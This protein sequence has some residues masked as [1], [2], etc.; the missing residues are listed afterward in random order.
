MKIVCIAVLLGLSLGP[1][2]GEDAKKAADV[3]KTP[4]QVI[5]PEEQT[6][7]LARRLDGSLDGSFGVFANMFMVRSQ[8]DLGVC[9]ALRGMT[10]ELNN[11]KLQPVFPDFY[12]PT[13]KELLD[14][15]ALQTSSSWSYRKEDQFATTSVPGTKVDDHVVIF[16]FVAMEPGTKPAKPFRVDFAK[17]WKSEDRGYWLACIP[18]TFPVG[19]DIYEMGTYS[20]DDKAD[21][22]ALFAKVR[23]EVAL[24]WAK[25]VKSDTQAADLK[26]AKVGGYEALHFEALLPTRN[27][28]EVRWRHW[29]FM[30]DNACYFIVSTIFP[31]M[32]ATLF[33]DVEKM[34]SSFK[35]TKK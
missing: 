6:K 12:K 20:A 26:P 29:V 11:A 32:E 10:S 35:V 3:R 24:Q 4:L 28:K 34:L 5:S 22:A 16:T 15:I 9:L 21:E 33:P 17:D 1:A 25:R 8:V 30:V 18:P 7:L 23:Q 27:G 13:L 19:M 14:T 31:E 2:F